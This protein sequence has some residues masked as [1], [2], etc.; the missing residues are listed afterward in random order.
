MTAPGPVRVKICGVTRLTDAVAAARLGASAI[1]F[2]FWP[3]SKRCITPAAAAPMV[4]ALPPDLLA[5]GV[6]V[7]PTREELLAAIRV[8][9]LRAVQLHGDE[10]PALCMELPVPVIKAVRV[11]DPASLAG[12]A[13]YHVAAYLLDAPGPGYGGSG[14]TFDW[15]LA[16]LAARELPVWLAG[17][18]TAENVGA[19]IQRVRPMGV[20]VASGVESAPGIKDEARMEAFIQAVKAAP[21]GA[22]IGKGHK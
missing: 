20:D 5:V 2:N 16:A 10:P 13:A 11:K 7:N 12:M 18:L 1:G 15:G 8:A 14:H 6:F 4:A 17:G 3:G 22:P 19:A 9:G 21:R